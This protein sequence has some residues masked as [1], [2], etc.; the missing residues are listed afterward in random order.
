MKSLLGISKWK[1]FPFS[2]SWTQNLYILYS[3]HSF[4][5][6]LPNTYKLQ[7]RVQHILVLGTQKSSWT[8]IY[9]WRYLMKNM[10]WEERRKYLTPQGCYRGF[11]SVDFHTHLE[12]GEVERRAGWSVGCPQGLLLPSEP[13][14][15]ASTCFYLL[16]ILG[17]QFWGFLQKKKGFT[18]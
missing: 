8:V 2:P 17:F 5:T 6:H 10:S 13:P 18:I 3:K 1:F 11:T 14:T 7:G 12:P 16:H 4:T 9:A 15:A